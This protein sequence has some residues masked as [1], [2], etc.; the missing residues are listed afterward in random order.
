MAMKRI[1]IGRFGPGWAVTVA[2]CTSLAGC[3]HAD[4][5]PWE[6]FAQPAEAYKPQANSGNAW[7]GYMLAA[8]LASAAAGP[9]NK[10]G[11]LKPNEE[12]QF[13]R[14]LQNS[15]SVAMRA[16][17]LP[18][19]AE[20]RPQDPF[21]PRPSGIGLTAIGRALGIQVKQA[22]EGDNANGAAQPLITAQRMADHLAQG[23]ADDALVGYWIAS[24]ARAQAAELLQRM[25]AQTLRNMGN[26]ILASLAGSPPPNQTVENEYK[27]ML[28]GVQFVQNAYR[29][30]DYPL[31]REAFY[32]QADPAI[33]HLEGLRPSDRP[34][35][36]KGFAG[37]AKAYV[38]WA[39]AALAVPASER[40]PIDL[41]LTGERPWRRFSMHLFTPL[42]AFVEARDLHIARSRLFALTCLAMAEGKATGKA[43]AEFVGLPEGSTTDPYSGRPF[44]YHRAER[45]FQIYSVGADGRDDGGETKGRGLA[46]DLTIEPPAEN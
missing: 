26:A 32:H 8:N 2:L 36:F 3:H 34:A 39:L 10:K 6:T 20:F 27:N 23:D 44:P 5:A 9:M 17:T 19:H 43:P 31:L 38:D 45:E 21:L 41:S 29:S 12:P 11:D 35:Y 40:K 37:E 42:T 22:K 30:K 14:R 13:A 7:D 16:S 4:D 15:V 33:E 24:N 18:C 28:L 25:D 46:P 1:S